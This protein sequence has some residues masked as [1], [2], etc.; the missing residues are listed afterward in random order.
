[1][2]EILGRYQPLQRLDLFWT[3]YCTM[4]SNPARLAQT[5]SAISLTLPL[6]VTP[7]PEQVL[8]L[9]RKMNVREIRAVHG[10][11]T[12]NEPG[13]PDARHI[14]ISASASRFQHVR[15]CFHVT[16]SLVPCGHVHTVALSKLLKMTSIF[17]S[18][19]KCV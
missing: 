3:L 12:V 9:L 11:K 14:P 17:K 1:M 5:T 8:Q 10:K 7:K 19:K 2:T 4:K 18:V 15:I 13:R 6:W 16:G